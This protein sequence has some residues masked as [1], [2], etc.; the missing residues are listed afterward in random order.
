MLYLL[1][2]LTGGASLYS[3]A[4]FASSI[5]S[6]RELQLK[7]KTCGGGCIACNTIHARASSAIS[8]KEP[9]SPTRSKA[10]ELA[11]H[12]EFSFDTTIEISQRLELGLMTGGRSLRAK[13]RP[14][15]LPAGSSRPANSPQTLSPKS[16]ANVR[17]LSQATNKW[18]DFKLQSKTKGGPPSQTM[19][20]GLKCVHPWDFNPFAS[21]SGSSSDPLGEY[22]SRDK[23]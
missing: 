1:N 10:T 9:G 16:S 11:E 7:I 13:S 3:L 12:N 2:P 20:S 22:W 17:D 19:S 15:G 14:H 5:M 21:M 8:V 6:G 23:R 4:S 18:E